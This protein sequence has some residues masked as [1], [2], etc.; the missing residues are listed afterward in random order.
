MHL[1]DLN[2]LAHFSDGK[3]PAVQVL[4]RSAH[5]RYLLFSFRKGQALREH[6]TSSQISVQLLSGQMTFT[7]RAVTHDLLPGHLL[8]LEAAVPHS[9]QAQADSLMLLT[10]TPDPQQ[11]TL[12]AELF[13]SIEP[14][15]N[16]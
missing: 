3:A 7:A 9:V 8:L 5:A 14:L 16:N 11:H 10:M 2:H 15:I 6:T 4:A 1:F 12:A 13:S